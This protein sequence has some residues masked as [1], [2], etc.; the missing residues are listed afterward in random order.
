[1]YFLFWSSPAAFMGICVLLCW[2]VAHI[3]EQQMKKSL[4]LPEHQ[5][6]HGLQEKQQGQVDKTPVSSVHRLD[7]PASARGHHLPDASLT[8]QGEFL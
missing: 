7:A 2:K 1:M 5:E 8:R 6:P 3:K 4:I